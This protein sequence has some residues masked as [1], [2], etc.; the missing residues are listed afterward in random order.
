MTQLRSEEADKERN[1]SLG[2]SRA[3]AILSD[4]GAGAVRL[5]TCIKVAQRLRERVAAGAR[6]RRCDVCGAL[7]C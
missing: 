1:R 2:L 4:A 5:S 3:F 7:R 6:A